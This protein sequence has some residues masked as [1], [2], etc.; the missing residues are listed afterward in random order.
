MMDSENR[1]SDEPSS[2]EKTTTNRL[3]GP[4]SDSVDPF[5]ATLPPQKPPPAAKPNLYGETLP[6]N[7][8]ADKG[9]PANQV[10]FTLESAGATTVTDPPAPPPEIPGYVLLDELGRGGMGVVYKALQSRLH[11]T[12]ALKMILAGEYAGADARIRF[13]SEAEV[14]ARLQHPNIVQLYEFNVHNGVA[15]FSLEFVDGGTLTDKLAKQPLAPAEAAALVETLARAVH[16]AHQQG[17]VHRDL[18]P[19][20]ILLQNRPADP[21]APPLGPTESH[22]SRRS[23]H[24]DASFGTLSCFVRNASV[25]PKITDFGLA[26]SAGGSNDLTKTGA[27]MGTPSYMAPEQ[28]GGKSKDVAAAADTYALGAILYEC[29]AGRPPFF[30]AT[31]ID[32]I[33]QVLNEDP[34]PPRRLQSKVP[35]DLETICLKC[36]HKDPTRRYATTLE[37]ADDLAR[38]LNG[39]AIRARP[40]GPVERG[41]RWARRHKSQTALIAVSVLSLVTIAALGWITSAQLGTALKE[42]KEQR[43]EADRQRTLAENH[44]NEAERQK[45]AAV[46][47]AAE[48]ERQRDEANRQRVAVAANLQ[49]RVDAVEG[50]L[51][52]IDR[53]LEEERGMDSIRREFLDDARTMSDQ[54]L[55]EN[56]DD[57]GIL[58]QAAQVYHRLANVMRNGRDYPNSDKNYQTA[59]KLQKQLVER[60]PENAEH[61]NALSRTTYDR[62]W[63]LWLSKRPTLAHVEF[64][65]AIAL[66]DRRAAQGHRGAAVTSARLR[67]YQANVLQELDRRPEAIALYRDALARQEKLAADQPDDADVLEDVGLTA[68]SLAVAIERDNPDEAY[69]LFRKSREAHQKTTQL[70]PQ[71]RRYQSNARDALHDLYAFCQQQHRDTDLADIAEEYIRTEP[72]RSIAAYNCACYYALA[73]KA[74]ANH[75]TLSAAEKA[76]R[77][78]KYAGE[79]VKRLRESID[80]GFTDR[81]HLLKDR[82]LDALRERDDYK[83]FVAELEERFPGRPITPADLLASLTEEYDTALLR[84]T[85]LRQTSRTIADRERAKRARPDFP[86]FAERVLKL[87]ADHE[88]TPAGVN[89]LIWI[90]QKTG[91]SIDPQA[92]GYAERAIA[93][94]EKCTERPEFATACKT[95]AEYSTPSGDTLL[96]K[97][98][99]SHPKHDVRGVATFTLAESLAKQAETKAS[100][101]AAREKLLQEAEELY[102]R[103]ENE[104][105]DVAYQDSTLGELAKRQLYTLRSLTEGRLAREIAGTAVD[106]QPIALSD[107]KGKVTL[108]LFW[109]NW[110]G[111]CRQLF[112]ATRQWSEQYKDR[113]FAILGV[114]TD[115]DIQ[116][117]RRAVQIGKLPWRS[118]W[119]GGATERKIAAEW[120]IDAYPTIYLI[121]H[122]GV[123]RK[124]WLGKPP[125]EQIQ[126]EIDALLKQVPPADR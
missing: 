22:T 69:T 50:M 4:V 86:D 36:L 67:Y 28:A 31:P 24:G 13:L 123:I 110:C 62:A 65:D 89:A 59:I 117:A 21:D 10:T 114:N 11:R 103:T 104:F 58:Q 125:P 116:E 15:Y 54:L 3:V 82:D 29:L 30:A 38:F 119:D 66:Y 57:P 101:R 80:Q 72:E 1:D 32:T 6:P 108:V 95:L 102:A 100:S 56:P 92:K 73:A 121:D 64:A 88:T 87:A 124:K 43:E 26:K 37:L 51:M 48:A 99:T 84:Y 8:Q 47:H 76:A 126:V 78:E 41:Y 91:L 83:A 7:S 5:A 2:N 74:V 97:A 63:M 35:K 85:R 55:K 120:L 39:E 33:M 25:I 68:C 23:L 20:N 19:G 70:D 113:P 106:D 16:Y 111:F 9:D 34:V 93:L 40:V 71:T 49:Q 107:Y 61:L 90:L 12:V 46:A 42:A 94:L 45:Q 96:R 109:A 14:I 52:N 60:F 75:P 17:I 98:M 118:V 77:R 112:P 122:A 27:I 18:K 105:N 53:R 79:A 81:A 44:A 115:A